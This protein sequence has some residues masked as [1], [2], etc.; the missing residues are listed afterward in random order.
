MLSIYKM[1]KEDLYNN[2]LNKIC[3]TDFYFLFLPFFLPFLPFLPFFPFFPF[4][5]F[6]LPFPEIKINDRGKHS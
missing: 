2:C 5:P 4:F 1:I 3:V 6:P